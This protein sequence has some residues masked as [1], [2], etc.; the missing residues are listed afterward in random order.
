M[1]IGAGYW[2]QLPMLQNQTRNVEGDVTLESIKCTNNQG[3]VTCTVT[4]FEEDG[5]L[6]V[7]PLKIIEFHGKTECDYGLLNIVYPYGFRAT[8]SDHA[9]AYL[10]L[11]S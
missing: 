3:S 6:S 8:V 1:G 11:Y 4:A 7:D 5:A 9:G 10:I 2:K